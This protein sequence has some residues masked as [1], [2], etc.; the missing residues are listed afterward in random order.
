MEEKSVLKVKN[1]NK[2]FGNIKAVDGLSFEVYEGEIFGILGPN[3]AGKSTTL[4]IITGLV[5]PNAGDINIFGYNLKENFIKAIE[6]LGILLENPGFY[7][8]LTGYENLKLFS[9][10]RKVDKKEIN[11]SLEALGL[12]N[13]ANRK[14]KDYSLGMRRRLGLAN[15]ILGKPKFLV[16]DEPTNGLDPLG[17]KTILNLLRELSKG[18]KISIIISSNLLNDVEIICDRVLLIDEG[19]RIF[20]ESVSELV[21]PI[22]NSFNIRVVPAFEAFS[23]LKKFNSVIKVDML[24]LNLIKVVLSNISS[25]ELNRFLL[26]KGCDVLEITPI[27]KTLQEIFLELKS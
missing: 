7:N 3:G 5:K 13:Q 16:L 14:V 9:R 6:N 15:A 21:K 4:S 22:E 27:R 20:C 11:Y 18:E 25:A 2:F 23:F 10:L 17:T 26:K 12:K 1:L 19:K 24:D 8:Y